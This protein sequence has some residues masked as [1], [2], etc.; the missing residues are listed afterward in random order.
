MSSLRGQ[1]RKACGHKIRHDSR[2]AAFAHNAALTR[3]DA[4][5]FGEPKRLRQYGRM[6]VYRCPFCHGW[7]VG[8]MPARVRQAIAAR[9]SS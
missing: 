6:S 9:R 7:H 8:H 5:S 1:R 4:C 2:E 3:A